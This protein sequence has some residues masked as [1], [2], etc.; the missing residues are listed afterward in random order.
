MR[1]DFPFIWQPKGVVSSLEALPLS[2][3]VPQKEDVTLAVRDEKTSGHPLIVAEL[4]DGKI[5]GD[6]RLAAT[7]DDVVIG[8]IQTVFGSDNLEGHYALR[9]RRLR[10]PR[11]RRGT[12]LLL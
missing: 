5:I 8:G 11:K 3:H 1:P 6:L 12:A 4:L 10:L 7:C 2:R 9:R